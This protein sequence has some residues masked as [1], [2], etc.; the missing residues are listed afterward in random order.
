M[1]KTSKTTYKNKETDERKGRI[2]YRERLISDELLKQEL[3]DSEKLKTLNP[4]EKYYNH[5]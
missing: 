2:K 5:E 4:E 1:S 3:E